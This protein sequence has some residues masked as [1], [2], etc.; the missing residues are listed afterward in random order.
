M[1][2]QY[3]QK[4]YMCYSIQ[5]IARMLNIG[6]VYSHINESYQYGTHCVRIAHTHIQTLE[7][8]RTSIG[9]EMR[10]QMDHYIA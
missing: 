10:T 7:H 3:V 1:I 9:L 6:I 2:F 8:D 4:L 5:Y